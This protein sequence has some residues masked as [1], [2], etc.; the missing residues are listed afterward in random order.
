ML[1]PTVSD[2]PY[3]QNSVI[4]KLERNLILL[5]VIITSLILAFHAANRYFFKSLAMIELRSANDSTSEIN[6]CAHL[7]D[8]NHVNENEKALYWGILWALFVGFRLSGLIILRKKATK[9]Y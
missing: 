4:G 3:L 8:V 6:M 7:L 2:W 9:F 5:L 1:L